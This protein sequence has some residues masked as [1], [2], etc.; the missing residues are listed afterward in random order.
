MLNKMGLARELA[1]SDVCGDFTY[2]AISC[3]LM[4]TRRGVERRPTNTS[5]VKREESMIFASQSSPFLPAKLFKKKQ[6][7]PASQPL[8][9]V[10]ERQNGLCLPPK[11]TYMKPN[12][13]CLTSKFFSPG[14]SR[15]R[16][17]CAQGA[18]KKDK[19]PRR[20]PCS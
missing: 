7:V 4:T 19:T 17:L 8:S 14:Q 1:G 18:S 12:S 10:A 2:I 11:P 3:I 5:A 15:V 9:N 16:E 13:L 20:T 6:L